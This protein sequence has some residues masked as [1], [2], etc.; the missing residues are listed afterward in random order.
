VLYNT[1]L[2]QV[3]IHKA[4]KAKGYTV[5]MLNLQMPFRMRIAVNNGY[6]LSDYQPQDAENI[7]HYLNDLEIYNNTL[8][9]PHPYLRK[10]A[11]EFLNRA[12]DRNDEFGMVDFAIRQ[13]NG[14]LVGAI[15]RFVHNGLDGHADEIG[16]WLGAPFRGQ[17]LMTEVLMAF[18]AHLFRTTPLVR[19]TAVVFTHN[20]AS[21]RALEKAGFERE[22]TMQKMA[23][24]NGLYYDCWLY[25]KIKNLPS[26]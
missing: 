25:A 19:I 7:T 6:Y 12:A 14:D 11:L 24:K 16:Y 23:F 8:R 3:Y 9:I 2:A 1:K 15:G 13:S 22:G 26:I 18:T 21:A 17:G 4:K 5:E 10:D 20:P